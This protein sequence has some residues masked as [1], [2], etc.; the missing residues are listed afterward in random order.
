VGVITKHLGVENPC[1]LKSTLAW[2]LC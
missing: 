2:A 1:W